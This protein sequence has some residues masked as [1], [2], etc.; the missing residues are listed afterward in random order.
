VT[1]VRRL[2]GPALGT[3]LGAASAA[4]ALERPESSN[5]EQNYVLFC[6]GCH[7][8]EGTGV[9]RR[10]P[11][12]AGALGPFLRAEGG[13]ELLLSFPGVVNS[14]LSDAA[15]ADV[16]NW[17]VTTF[18]AGDRPAGLRPYTAAD[19]HAARI[20]PQLN[21]QRSRRELMQRLG[22]PARADY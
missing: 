13:R 18:A 8:V 19:V 14:A 6:G 2:L 5:V 3:L 22:L 10:V 17:C 4:G 7:G 21:V 1:S 9:P 11:P 20:E 16:M 15:L 12:L